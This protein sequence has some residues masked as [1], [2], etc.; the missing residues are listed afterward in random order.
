[1]LRRLRLDTV[2]MYEEDDEEIEVFA[3]GLRD[4]E[5]RSLST[6]LSSA[7]T[8]LKVLDEEERI[9]PEGSPDRE[10]TIRELALQRRKIGALEEEIGRRKKNEAWPW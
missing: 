5:S 7:Y 6:E 10:R 8:R 2:P 1:M 4:R 9:N 3:E